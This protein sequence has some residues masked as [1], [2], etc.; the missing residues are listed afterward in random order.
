MSEG[1]AS[2]PLRWLVAGVVAAPLCTVGHEGGHYLAGWLFD[3]PDLE[4]HGDAVSS[5]SFSSEL[6]LSGRS[7][8]SSASSSVPAWGSSPTCA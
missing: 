7:H 8:A 1:R 2:P 6:A 5:V 4:F 3:F